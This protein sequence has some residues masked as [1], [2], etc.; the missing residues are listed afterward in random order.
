MS[1]RDLLPLLNRSDLHIQITGNGWVT[2]QNPQPGTPVTEHM[3][4]ELTLE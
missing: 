4:I 1:K 3:T 2:S